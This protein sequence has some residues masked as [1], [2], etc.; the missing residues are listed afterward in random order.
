M[1]P[2]VSPENLG[3][4]PCWPDIQTTHFNLSCIYIHRPILYRLSLSSERA[5]WVELWSD[6]F[7][8]NVYITLWSFC[9]GPSY[10]WNRLRPSVSTLQ[11]TKHKVLPTNLSATASD[12]AGSNKP[13]SDIRYFWH[14]GAS[15]LSTSAL[16]RE[17]IVTRTSISSRRALLSW[18]M[19]DNSKTLTYEKVWFWLDLFL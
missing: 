11:T 17:I 6:A 16:S 1:Y 5:S 19:I 4:N 13:M 3:H 8:S 15:G 2:R 18:V 10:D 12:S 7:Q 9:I 14:P